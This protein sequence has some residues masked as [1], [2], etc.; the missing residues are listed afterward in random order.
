MRCPYCNAPESKVTDSRSGE[1]KSF[2]RRR[3]ECLDCGRRFT[4]YERIEDI[5]LVIIKK[6]DTREVFS[7]SKL[8]G[9][10]VRACEK[11]PISMQQIE[12]VAQ[13][14]EQ[15]AANLLNKEVSS[16]L[17]G[18][19]VMEELKELDEVAYVRFASVYKSFKD[20]ESFQAELEEL[21]REK[22]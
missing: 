9:G 12:S 13:R 22:N 20:I 1:D 18:Q 3:R 10:I 17:I 21:K 7:R 16:Q 6:D 15:K 4:T 8:I 2:I 11:R 5:N 19:F 14:I